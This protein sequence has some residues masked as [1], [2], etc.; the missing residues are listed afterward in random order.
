MIGPISWLLLTLT[1]QVTVLAIAIGAI[2]KFALGKNPKAAARLIAFGMLLLLGVTAA[3]T[4]PFPSWFDLRSS[5]RSH[6][7]K[8][9]IDDQDSLLS[10]SSFPN[11]DES[12]IFSGTF[13]ENQIVS[14]GSTAWVETLMSTASQFDGSATVATPDYSNSITWNGVVCFGICFLGLCVFG[15][16]RLMFGL[17]AL[18]RLRLS[19]TAVSSDETMTML[20][21]LCQKIGCDREISL[22]QTPL[23]GTAATM[24]LWKPGI[25]LADDFDYW[26]QAEQESVL[27][28]EIAHIHHGDFAANIISQICASMHFFNPAVHWLVGQMRLNQEVAADQIASQI[29]SGTGEY[30]RTLA[31]L[32]LRQDNQNQLRLASMFIS[33]QNSFVRRIT[34]LQHVNRN[35]SATVRWGT[36]LLTTLTAFAI[37]GF[38]APASN[39]EATLGNT[40]IIDIVQETV[41]QPSNDVQDGEITANPLDPDLLALEMLRQLS[42][43]DVAGSRFAESYTLLLAALE[44]GPHNFQRKAKNAELNMLR[45][46]FT[47]DPIL[48]IE[49]LEVAQAELESL[50]AIDKFHHLEHVLAM[51]KLVEVYVRLGDDDKAKQALEMA[52]SKVMRVAKLNPENYDVWRSLV[53]CAVA[54]KDYDRANEFIRTAYQLVKGKETRERIMK[55]ASLVHIQNA[56]DFIEIDN[57]TN[58]RER[59]FALCNAIAINPGDVRI[60]D[61]LFEYTDIDIDPKRRDVWLRNS[62]LECRIPGVVHIL[63]G[64]RELRRGDPVAGKTSWD[65][66][67]HQFSTTP[68][69]V[70]RLLSVAMRKDPQFGKGELLETALSRFPDQYLLYETRGLLKKQNQKFEEAIDDFKI[71]IEKEPGLLAAHQNLSDCYEKIGDLK[72]MAIHKKR[73][74]EILQSFNETQ[75][76]QISNVLATDAGSGAPAAV[77]NQLGN[78]LLMRK[79]YSKA[80]RYYQK[81]REKSPKDPAILNNLAYI[82]T[83]ATD[84]VH[85]PERALQLIDE[86]ISNLPSNIATSEESRFF[87]TKATALKQL[88]KLEEAL[89][90]F[91]LALKARPEHADSLRSVIECYRALN[92]QTPEQYI[93][94]LEQIEEEKKQ[95]KQK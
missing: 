34:M 75:R 4:I 73:A 14:P 16:G 21:T 13:S 93:E 61:R 27:A 57:E 47:Q 76:K 40:D 83:I 22:L 8:S 41:D 36:V 52:S 81:A 29:T 86:A 78:E 60:Y 10:V 33:N 65:I 90:L 72:N 74:E 50:T 44:T 24:G 23:V 46:H 91:E 94:R 38:R 49:S 88:D 89:S 53:Q 63:L 58:F 39:S 87:H 55:L 85:N 80:I 43:D 32:A 84:E 82:Y 45:A 25:F 37:S 35:S 71:V 12:E 66:A 28:H 6:A 92:L 51:P 31:A 54:V 30:A 1:I 3:V 20:R 56:D 11:V 9:S 62:I 7:M 19:S 67:Q 77:L 68:F 26:E 18:R 42:V 15:F 5:D 79:Q 69:V 95:A 59:L 64:I 17:F 48:K 2:Q 70:H